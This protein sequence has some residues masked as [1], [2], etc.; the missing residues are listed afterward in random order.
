MIPSNLG[1]VWLPKILITFGKETHEAILDVGS[2]VSMLSKELYDL[3][4]LKTTEK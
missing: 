2:S 3:I 4:E 1:D